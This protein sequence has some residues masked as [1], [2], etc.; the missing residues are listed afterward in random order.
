M[1]G[2]IV[3]LPVML[4]DEEDRRIY[5][6]LEPPS[7]IVVRYGREGRIA[8]LPYGGDAKPGCGSKLVIETARGAEIGEML[9]T[10]C[11]N[12]G[13]G[14]SVSRRQML[15]YIERSGGRD[16]P[17]TD[18]GKVLRVA[19]REDMEAQARL[20]EE[21][22][23][24]KR[25]VQ[26][27]ADGYGL[28]MRVV[29]VER[30]LGGE[31]MIVHYTAEGY[32]DFRELVRA[33]GRE[34]KRRV[35]MRQVNEREEAR[36]AAD[37]NVCGQHCCCKQ[38]LKVL[39]PVSMGMARRQKGSVDPQKISGR[40]GRL[41]CCLRYEDQ[42][43]AELRR[44]LPDRRKRVQTPEGEGE[45]VSTQVLTQLVLVEL[46]EGT[47]EQARQAFPVEEIRVIGGGGGKG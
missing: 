6:N 30:L 25:R 12:S 28:Q 22:P 44:N 7:T 24:V 37:Y 38:F 31:R 46:D 4:E 45:V 11:A 17:F 43:Y 18:Q 14:K 15:E 41:M 20:E 10:T 1:P 8:E 32:V 33:L 5:E 27:V 21:G 2:S 9:T 34:F 42:T 23:A 40:C 26:E 47:G 29:E 19:T 13:C 36:L 39:K 35:Q 3:P 16:Y